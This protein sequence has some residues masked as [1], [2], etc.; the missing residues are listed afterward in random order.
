[1]SP[2]IRQ[3][4]ITTSI[5][6]APITNRTGKPRKQKLSSDP[7]PHLVRLQETLN[8]DGKGLSRRCW[9][10]VS[11]LP[12]GEGPGKKRSC[13]GSVPNPSPNPLPKGEGVK[14]K[15]LIHDR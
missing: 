12:L 3:T 11:F 13:G 14:D 5:S 1:M 2:R 6:T 10:D 9:F 8:K 4:T 15:L 7:K